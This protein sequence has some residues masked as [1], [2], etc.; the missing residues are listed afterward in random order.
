M[1]NFTQEYKVILYESYVQ[2]KS[3]KENQRKFKSFPQKH[4]IRFYQSN[5]YSLYINK[6]KNKMLQNEA[7]CC[8]AF[9]L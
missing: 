6:Q 5:K 3:T 2:Y 7:V 9:H 4:Y 8:L 1:E